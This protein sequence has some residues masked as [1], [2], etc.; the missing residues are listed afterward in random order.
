MLF[1]RYWLEIQQKNL[2]TLCF[3]MQPNLNNIILF[4]VTFNIIPT[5]SIKTS[6]WDIK[7]K[8]IKMWQILFVFLIRIW[9]WFCLAK[10]NFV[11]ESNILYTLYDTPETWQKDAIGRCLC[12]CVYLLVVEATQKVRT[13][14]IYMIIVLMLVW[15]TRLY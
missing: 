12:V 13:I 7:T 11:A 2:L 15:G 14:Y 6:S 8:C 4:Q 3:S 1:N 5:I 9:F 10:K